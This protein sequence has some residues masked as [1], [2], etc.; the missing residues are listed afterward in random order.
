MIIFLLCSKQGFDFK[1]IDVEC[2]S[3]LSKIFVEITNL[4]KSTSL[5]L[6]KEPEKRAN[7]QYRL[8]VWE[9]SFVISLTLHLKSWPS[10]FLSRSFVLRVLG[11]PFCFLSI[12]KKRTAS[13]LRLHLWNGLFSPPPITLRWCSVYTVHCSLYMLDRYHCSP[14]PN[15][16]IYTIT[17]CSNKKHASFVCRFVQT[18]AQAPWR[19]CRRESVERSSLVWGKIHLRI[20]SRLRKLF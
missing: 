2:F 5:C 16:S 1:Q 17:L 3:T 11:S 18:Q 8:P 15:A 20:L 12:Q 13:L 14:D 6:Q 9:L 4:K 19:P 10:S 7:E